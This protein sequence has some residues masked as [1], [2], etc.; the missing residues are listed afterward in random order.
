M[1]KITD[2]AP[3][4]TALVEGRTCLYFSGFSYLGMHASHTFRDLLAVGLGRFGSVYPSSRISNLQLRLYE[5][6]EHALATQ[7]HQ[8]SAVCFSSGYLA[9]QAA[10]TYAATRG[11]VLFAPSAH[12]ALRYPGAE[13]PAGNWNDWL[14]TVVDMVNL[15]ADYQYVLVSDAVNPL[16]AVIND[17]SPL[18]TLQKK[19]L[20]LI[21]DSHGIG[22]LGREGEGISPLLPPNP[23]AHYLITAS[24]AKAYSL[25]G[26]MVAGHAA[27]VAAIRHLPL[28]TASTP[29]IPANAYAFLHA[30]N[31]FTNARRKLANNIN[32]FKRL[33]AGLDHLQHPHELPVFILE[34]RTE[35][36]YSYLLSRDTFI[37]SFAYP[38]PQGAKINRIILSA[39]HTGNDLEILAGQLTQYYS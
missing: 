25:E 31:A 37:S 2:T 38:D 5:E 27:D 34:D 26:G 23:A 32:M 29:M 11:Q 28:F 18:A 9:A 19:A 22:L 16:T 4:R 17:F 15:G 39:L 24:L 3:G 36:V 21:D 33:T 10:I 6:L 13:V 30:G 20:V 12:P 35:S 7:L 1:V 14:A 8:Q